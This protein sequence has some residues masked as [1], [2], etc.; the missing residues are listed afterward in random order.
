MSG[1]FSGDDD[2]PIKAAA[3]TALLVGMAGVMVVNEGV[4]KIGKKI[5]SIFKKKPQPPSNA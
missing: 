3:T 1:V 5:G 2:N 4:R